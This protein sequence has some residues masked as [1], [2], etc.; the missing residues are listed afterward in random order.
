MN[1]NQ[2][3]KSEIAEQLK[4][5]TEVFAAPEAGEFPVASTR[6]QLKALGAPRTEFET[7]MFNAEKQRLTDAAHNLKGRNIQE[8]VWSLKCLIEDV[9]GVSNALCGEQRANATLALRHLEDAHHRMTLA[10][11]SNT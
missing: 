3:Q 10:Q 5:I 9:R 4:Q 8:V 7:A 11:E 6:E 1:Q 2:N